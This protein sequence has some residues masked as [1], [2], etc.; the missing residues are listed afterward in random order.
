[1]EEIRE[2][3][4]KDGDKL[5]GVFGVEVIRQSY[6]FERHPEALL[7]AVCVFVRDL[8]P[9]DTGV[10]VTDEEHA[11]KNGSATLVDCGWT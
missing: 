5:T 3:E 8:L 1:M 10:E 7:V 4:D 9:Y 6:E 11:V 2:E